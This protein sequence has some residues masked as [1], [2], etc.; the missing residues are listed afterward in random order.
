[1]FFYI[2]KFAWFI[3]APGNLLFLGLLLGTFLLWTRWRRTGVYFLSVVSLI[4]LFVAVVPIGPV[5]VNW[6]EDRFQKPDI[7]SK[8]I[9]GIIVLGGVISPGL[10][11]SRNE[12]SFGSATERLIAF[13][14]L[15]KEHPNAK[16]VFTGGSGDPFNPQLS[17]AKMIQPLL[18]ELGMDLDR[19]VFET[20][21]RN[22]VENAEMTYQKLKPQHEENWLL[23]TSAFH[24]PRAV[25]CFRRVGWNIIPYPVDYGTMADADLPALQFNFTQG[26]NYLN[27]A[28]HEAIGLLMYFV[29]GKTDALFPGPIASQ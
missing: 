9:D 6:Y 1:M 24:M 2:S 5:A 25:G 28:T 19:I 7:K 15:A 13:A 26:L 23:V 21:S 29:T 8:P 14:D 17:E 22:T 4:S 3:V 27:A 16:L 20:E 10:S 18:K 11:I 12:L